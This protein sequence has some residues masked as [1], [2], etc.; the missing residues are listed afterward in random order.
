MKLTYMQKPK[1]C[2]EILK[3]CP[4]K[5]TL[6]QYIALIQWAAEAR[7]CSSSWVCTFA[8]L[9]GMQSWCP[10]CFMKAI[11]FD[12]FLSLPKTVKQPTYCRLNSKPCS[13]KLKAGRWGPMTKI[14][15]QKL[16]LALSLR[17]S[18]ETNE[19]LLY[20]GFVHPFLYQTHL[21]CP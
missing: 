7:C 13:L 2:S 10:S 1:N 5:F 11:Y 21:M 19:S 12:N 8:V 6:D 9:R 17:K 14:V 16:C 20:L 18:S 3:A 15:I 4:W